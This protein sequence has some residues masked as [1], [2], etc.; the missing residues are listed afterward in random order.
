[1]SDFPPDD[2]EFNSTEEDFDPPF[3]GSADIDDQGSHVDIYADE[4]DPPEGGYQFRDVFNILDIDPDQD[5]LFNQITID[6]TENFD[7]GSTDARGPYDRDE[8]IE[9]LNDTGWWG[10]ADVYYDEETDS[11]FIDINYDDGSIS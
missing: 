6:G 11:Y 3:L 4:S 10:I 7:A 5:F 2:Y 1:M 9:F 8:A